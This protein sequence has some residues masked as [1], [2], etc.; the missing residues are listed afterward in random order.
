MK[1]SVETYDCCSINLLLPLQDTYNL[2]CM[3]V[4]AGYASVS[5]VTYF[6]LLYST[7]IFAEQEIV[8]F[9]R[10]IVLEM[11]C[12]YQIFFNGSPWSMLASARTVR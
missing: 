5:V 3:C 2:Y 12:V 10:T 8:V 11:G 9:E 6:L 7:F 4:Y 1:P